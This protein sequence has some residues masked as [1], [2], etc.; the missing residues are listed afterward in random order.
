[1]F[2]FVQLKSF[3]VVAEELHFGRAA[4]RLQMTQPPL[5]RQIRKLEDEVGFNLFDR[6]KRAVALTAAGESFLKEAR[7]LLSLAEKSKDVAQRI[8]EGQGGSVS[9]SL[10]AMGILALLPILID[11][12]E[13]HAPELTLEIHEMVSRDQIVSVL[14]GEVD[15]GVVRIP[16]EHEELES[17]L[18]HSERLFAAVSS[19]HRLGVSQA[20]LRVPSLAGEP[21]IRYHP[22]QAGFF[23]DLTRSVLR[24]TSVKVQ[25]QVTQVHSMISLVATNHGLAFVPESATHL[26][27][28]GVV[29]RPIQGHQEKIVPLYAV[30]RRDNMNPAFRVVI[31]RLYSLHK[32]GITRRLPRQAPNSE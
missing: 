12:I 8:A 29:Y 14:N 5:S 16:P 28:S 11:E 24:D 9:V 10:T 1:M 6:S 25:Q 22:V 26:Q 15:V 13:E 17:V 30:W 4:D 32:R 21:F 19:K 2:T 18:V 23:H 31:K 20:P 7:K 27:M 3:I